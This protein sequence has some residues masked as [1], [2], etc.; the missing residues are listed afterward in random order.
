MC[1][2]SFRTSAGAL[3][4]MS[5]PKFIEAMLSEA[6]SGFIFTIGSMRSAI[7]APTAPPV[8]T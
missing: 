1:A 7:G 3:R 8:E 4:K 2:A 6:I 5:S